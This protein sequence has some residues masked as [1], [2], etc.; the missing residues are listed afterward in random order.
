[1]PSSTQQ[2]IFCQAIAEGANGA[3]AARAAGY[4]HDSAAQTAFKLLQRPDVIER[5]TAIQSQAAEQRAARCDAFIAKLEPVLQSCLAAG[6]IDR[7]LEIF[8]LQARVAGLVQGGA[9]V[10]RRRQR[11]D[12][13]AGS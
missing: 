5:V 4:A 10:R 8:E 9:T 12:Q 1:M 7:A 11:R 13:P 2:E 3:D 6:D